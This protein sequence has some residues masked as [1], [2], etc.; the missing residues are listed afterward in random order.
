MN[1]LPISWVEL[2]VIVP[3][4]GALGVARFRDLD[5]ARHW[6]VALTGL[7]LLCAVGAWR[8][9]Q[10]VDTTSANSDAHLT[11]RILGC[12]VFE[13]DQLSAPLLPLTALLYFLTT[14]TTLRTKMPYF[15]FALTLLSES[16]ALATTSCR[17]PWLVIGLLGTSTVIPYLE[18]VA[19]ER[20]TRVYVI[21]AALFVALMVLGQSFV[22]L[23]PGPRETSAWAL[24]PLLMA[25][26]VRSGIVPFHCWITDLFEHASF[27][28]ALLVV[29]P[30]AGAYGA[31]RLILP[32]APIGCCAV[33]G[34]SR[35]RQR[36]TP[37]EWRSF[38]ATR[39]DSSVFSF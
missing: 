37:R 16:L 3:L 22:E 39:A 18:L 32:I 31:V 8:D 34:W 38:S 5:R 26:L 24:I 2:A 15:S 23:F 11:T 9:F 33:W 17:A 30:L 35:W 14:V 29:A 4:L 36:S 7:A 12:E 21:H 25:V 19:R 28:T 6:S 1:D 20:P 10:V 13:I 27:A